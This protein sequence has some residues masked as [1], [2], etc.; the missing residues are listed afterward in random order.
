[1]TL[2]TVIFLDA[3]L[4]DFDRSSAYSAA[5]LGVV[6]AASLANHL[7][8]LRQE[9]GLLTNGVD[10]AAVDQSVASGRMTGYLPGKGRGHLTGILELLGRLRLVHEGEFWSLVQAEVRRLPWGATL[11]FVVPGESSVLL[12]TVV[13]LKRSGF[14]VVLVYL[15]Y[16]DP[17]SFDLAERRARTMGVRAYRVWRETDVDVW[18]RG[19]GGPEVAGAGRS[20]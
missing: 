1:M 12:D 18:R 16:P 3:L 2:Q 15:D 10:P 6:V 20:S 9:V 5:E 8:D 4:G 17:V 11:A 14:S 19:N 13:M 7:V